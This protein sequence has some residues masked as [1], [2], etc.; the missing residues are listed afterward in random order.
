[1]STF[2]PI[3]NSIANNRRV[4]RVKDFIDAP[5]EAPND[6]PIDPSLSEWPSSGSIEFCNY[7]TRYREDLPC[8]LNDINLSI[9]PGEKIGIVGQTGAG[10]SSIAAALL[11]SVEADRG[12][13]LINRVDIST[14]GL[15]LL[16]QAIVI[17][18]QGM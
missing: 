14:L 15:H 17:V 5:S 12:Q 16:R 11:R 8:V 7:S 3:G 13:I 9:K 6:V 1:M 18:P 2:P 10:K 4:E